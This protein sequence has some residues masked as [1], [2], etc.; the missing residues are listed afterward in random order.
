MSR[1]SNNASGTPVA[2]ADGVGQHWDPARYQRNAGFVAAL[3]MP[4]VEL[5]APRPHERIPL[6]DQGGWFAGR[7]T[8]AAPEKGAALGSYAPI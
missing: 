4:V 1:P 3:G 7:R 6:D 2:P 8:G 5:L